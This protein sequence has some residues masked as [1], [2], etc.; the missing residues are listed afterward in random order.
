MIRNRVLAVAVRLELLLN[1]CAVRRGLD[2]QRGASTVEWVIIAAV[3]FLLAITVGAKIT[4]VV[5]EQLA[6]IK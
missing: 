4:S 1:R 6:K 5:D 2:P 3:V